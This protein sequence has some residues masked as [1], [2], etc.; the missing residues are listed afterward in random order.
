MSCLDLWLDLLAG[1]VY[2]DES[3]IRGS[4]AGNRP[5]VCFP[6]F[7]RVLEIMRAG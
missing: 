7:G 4:V 1:F 6:L 5:G 3:W 2:L